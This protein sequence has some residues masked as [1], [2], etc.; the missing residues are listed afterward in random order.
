MRTMRRGLVGLSVGAVMSVA[1]GA[2]LGAQ[3]AKPAATTKASVGQPLQ[4]ADFATRLA[5]VKQL[6]KTTPLVDAHNDLPWA[7]REDANAPLDVD[8]YDLNK[9]TKGMTDIARLRKGMVGGQFWSVY[10]PG[11]IRDSGY[12][13]VQL[14]QIDIA[15]R[16]IAR[17]PKDLRAGRSPP[18]MCARRT[19]P[20]RSARC[21]AWKAGTPSRTRLGAL[22]AYYDLGARYMTLTHNVT[23]DWADAAQRRPEAQRPHAVRQGSGARDEPAGHAGRPVAR[24]AGR[25]EQR[26]R[27]D[28]GAGDLLALG[29]ARRSPMCRATCPTPSS[30]ACRRT[31]AW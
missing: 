17:Y 22:R 23:L 10:I 9:P 6:L 24:L 25:D 15:R 21:W 14:E 18:P 5:H 19:R 1:T 26:A 28:R 12:A 11:E 8:A 7:M 13:R 27:R 16:V 30:R 3:A 4:N 2:E 29:G 20:A 31:A